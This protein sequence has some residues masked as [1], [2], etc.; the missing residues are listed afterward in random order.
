MS[1][2]AD[3]GTRR[4]EIKQRAQGH[5]AGKQQSQGAA[6]HLT[7]LTAVLPARAQSPT[8]HKLH[9]KLTSPL[10]ASCAPVSTLHA[11]LAVPIGLGNTPHTHENK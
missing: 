7:L 5:T 6:R 11:E 4:R 3:E 2:V 8:K 1:H 10:M 9:V